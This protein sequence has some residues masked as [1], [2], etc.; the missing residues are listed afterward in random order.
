MPRAKALRHVHGQCVHACMQA[1]RG[2]RPGTSAAT[3]R[4][5]GRGSHVL[6]IAQLARKVVLELAVTLH[7]RKVDWHQHQDGHA[8][9]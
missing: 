7:V 5:C 4:P 9:R 1:R 2:S 3:G 8:Y 6:D